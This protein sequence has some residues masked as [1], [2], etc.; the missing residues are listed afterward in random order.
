MRSRRR[1]FTLIELMIVVAV[2]G[3][4]AAISIP[5]YQSYVQRARTAEAITFLAEI[6]QR[7]ESYRAEFGQ[8]CSVS[9]APGSGIDSGAWAPAALP[10]GGDKIGWGGTPGDWNQLGA[11]PDGPVRFQYRTTAGPPGSSPGV[12]G[13]PGDDFWFVAQARGDLDADGDVVIFEVYS[14]TNQMFIGTGTYAPLPS[15]WE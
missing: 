13:F 12:P 1:G 9:A 2:I 3:I 8:F 4:L 11:S 6:R 7:Q 10:T 14:P 5:S 15:G